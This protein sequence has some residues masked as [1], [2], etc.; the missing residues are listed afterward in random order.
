MLS[1][2]DR[3]VSVRVISCSG[4]FCFV[5]EGRG[6]GVRECP[7][8]F[9]SLLYVLKGVLVRGGGLASGGDRAAAVAAAIDDC[10]IGVFGSCGSLIPRPESTKPGVCSHSCCSLVRSA[11]DLCPLPLLLPLEILSRSGVGGL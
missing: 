8:G 10:L 9:G 11:E 6:L 3:S 7:G 5:A 1:E 4:H 2:S